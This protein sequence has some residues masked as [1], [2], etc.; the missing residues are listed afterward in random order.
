[1]LKKLVDGLIFGA[2]FGVAFVAVWIAAIYFILPGLLEKRF[3]AYEVEKLHENVIGEV[4][5]IR[6]SNRFLGSLGIYSG[7][8][9]DN[10][11]GVL[12]AGD[13]EI[14]GIAL[15]N[16]KPLKGLKLR[17]A[18]N[19]KVMSQWATTDENGKYII[20]VPYGEYRIDGYE[21]DKNS[22]DLNLAGK[23]N[24]PQNAYSSSKF[25]VSQGVKGRG[26]TFRFID[27]IEKRLNKNRYSASEDITLHWMPYSGARWYAIQI[28]EK[29]DPQ[30]FFRGRNIFDWS[31][32]PKVSVPSINLKEYGVEVQA[33]HFYM[34]DIVAHDERMAILSR[35]HESHFGYDFEVIE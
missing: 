1:M 8:F 23:I 14:G 18:L 12:S 28:Y 31:S 10:K 7:N 19:G 35:T 27:P 34:L 33:G 22:A 6:D 9:L 29:K 5:L 4:P 20:H 30:S 16:E 3:G 13:G 17:L 2:G 24:H 26:L 11:E 21:L 15:V 25:Y 32:K